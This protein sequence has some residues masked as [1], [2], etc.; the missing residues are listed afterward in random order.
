MIDNM[1]FGFVPEKGMIDAILR[2]QEYLAKQKN[3]VLLTLKRHL[4]KFQ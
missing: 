2:L 4:M 3:C 1:K